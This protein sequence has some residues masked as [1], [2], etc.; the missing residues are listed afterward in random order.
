L[1]TNTTATVGAV[2]EGQPLD[3]KPASKTNKTV[4]GAGIAVAVV[5]AL[6]GVYVMTSKDPG[7]AG[8]VGSAGLPTPPATMSVPVINLSSDAPKVDA[9]AAVSASAAPSATPAV[10]SSADKPTKPIPGKPG[11]TKPKKPKSDLGF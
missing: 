9:S 10:S 7:A 1:Q 8:G 11:Q 5:L 6:A 4:V 2:E 3:A